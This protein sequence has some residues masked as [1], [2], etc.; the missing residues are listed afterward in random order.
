MIKAN[1]T[2][3]EII[4]KIIS[5]SHIVIGPKRDIKICRDPKDNMFLEC[6]ENAKADYIVSGDNDLLLLKQYKNIKIIRTS[7]I[8]KII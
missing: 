5:V 4:Q 1:L 6:A 8:L 2:A 7:D 3:E